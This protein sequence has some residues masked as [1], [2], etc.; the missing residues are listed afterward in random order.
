[1]AVG[2]L[3]LEMI[4]VFATNGINVVKDFTLLARA[5]VAIESTARVLDPSFSLTE[6][7]KPFLAQLARERWDPTVFLGEIY[8]S[9]FTAVGKLQE[10]PGDVQRLL[11]RFESQD[12]SMR[13]A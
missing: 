13:L 4:Y 2:N 6:T 5:V 9:V 8:R 11:R 3:I 12:I 10:L 7:A 1:E